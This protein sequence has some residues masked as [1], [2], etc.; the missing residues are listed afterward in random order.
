MSIT[1]VAL[2]VAVLIIVPSVFNGFQAEIR[3]N[4]ADAY[5]DL[6]VEART[7]INNHRQLTETVLAE[8]GVKRAVPYAHGMV[9]MQYAN[10][11][12]FP[13]VQGIDVSSDEELDT[14]A[15]H[16]V[17]GDIDDFYDDSVI[18][19][20]GIA[21]ALKLRVGETAMIYN[22]Q[23]LEQLTRD[24]VPLP[25]E[26]EIAAIVETGWY[27]VDE[28]TV[29]CTLRFMQELYGLGEGV[30]GIKAYVES[31]YDADKVANSLNG[32]LGIDF[33]ASSWRF[34]NREML[35]ILEFEN[36]MMFFLLF[37][38]LIVSAFSIMSSLLISVIRKTREIGVFS[39]MGA[40]ASQ[41]AACFCLQGVVI[42]IVGAAF[43]FVLGFSLI[44]VREEI[45]SAISNFMGVA[46]SMSEF[47]GFAYLPIDVQS[48]DLVRVAILAIIISTLAGI[49][50]AFKAALMKPVEALRSE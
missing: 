20:T 23:L 29:L 2:G 9:M 11:P 12:T 36:R 10:R 33:W 35:A 25:R 15:S 45:T 13:L 22:Q 44:G 32:K 4:L 34:A 37:I 27:E 6:R 46:E 7:I 19:S 21:T 28:N 1:G 5:G 18:I 40:T 24:E 50:P 30:H 31:G 48:D 17:E 14:V 47:Y 41:V 39:S 49:V 16:I 38:I 43:G 3:R 26:V 8:E 42:G